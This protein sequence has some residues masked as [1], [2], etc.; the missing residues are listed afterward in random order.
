MEIMNQTQGTQKHFF[1][2][3]NAADRLWAEWIA[4]QLMQAGYEVIYQHWD[5]PPGSNFV[6]EMDKA[7]KQAEQTIAI[8]SSNYVNALY[9]QTEW[10]AAF[11]E[12]P[13]G[14]K[15]KL[16]P[17]RVQKCELGGILGQIVRI[18]LVGLSEEQARKT[19]LEG[20]GREP[21]A[22]SAPPVYPLAGIENITYE[23][24]RFPKT[25]PRIWNVPKRNL[26]FTGRQIYLE[27]LH[28]AFLAE[29][30]AELRREHSVS[31]L[32]GIGKTEIVI[33]Y[34]YRYRSHYEAVLWVRADSKQSIEHD[35]IAIAKDYLEFSQGEIGNAII[36]VKRW[37]ASHTD[38]LLIF[39]NVGDLAL[40]GGYVP[41]EHKGHVLLTTQIQQEDLRIGSMDEQE[42]AEFLLRRV[43]NRTAEEYTL[44]CASPEEQQAARKIS[45]TLDGHPLALDQAGVYIGKYHLPLLGYLQRYE[46]NRTK[47]LNDRGDRLS[48]HEES[49]VITLDLSFE[50]LEERS[51]DAALLLQFLTFLYPDAI[52]RKIIDGAL[53]MGPELQPLA[54]DLTEMDRALG[55]LADF[56]LISWSNDET[57]SIH[58][59]VRNILRD[60]I[61]AD[62][63]RIW[64]ERAVKVVNRAFPDI[65]ELDTWH[66]C[67]ICLSHAQECAQLVEQWKMVFPEAARLLDQIGTFLSSHL[68]ENSQYTKA[69]SFF[70][71]GLE[72]RRQLFGDE[73]PDVAKSIY[74]LASLSLAR[75]DTHQASKLFRQAE[76]IWCR[77]LAKIRNDPGPSTLLTAHI[78]N[79]LAQLYKAQEDFDKAQRYYND[80]LAIYQTFADCIHLIALIYKDLAQIYEEQGQEEQAEQSY[81]KALWIYDNEPEHPKLV[82]ILAPFAAM[83]FIQAKYSQ[84]ERLYKRQ[85]KICE[86]I[87]G[88]AHP[89]VVKTLYTL[90]ALYEAQNKYAQSEPL[91]QQALTAL[92]G[93]LGT[94][95]PEVANGLIKLASL[96]RI[97]GKYAQAEPLYKRAFAIQGQTPEYV[98]DDVRTHL[99]NYV[100]TLRMLNREAEASQIEMRALSF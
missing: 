87:L 96:Y 55:N 42:G 7:M 94:N 99:N 84:A 68:L 31:G 25:R 62:T 78:L 36:D 60:K 23:P 97:Q 11:R 63:Q 67:Q 56:S 64:A 43:K 80:A 46:R 29:W 3:F 48:R 12:D 38:W 32:G 86:H 54:N 10:A 1:I 77:S 81:S 45:Q 58:H 4:Y 70:C 76:E 50:K 88:L 19:L 75:G 28:R 59:L 18:D 34:A 65:I 53:D 57:L 93:R 66:S 22:P 40:I 73:H 41:T 90:A 47:L 39:D 89:K 51:A 69:E 13:K 17:V 24:P 71:K 52:S 37:L 95:H 27:D 14:E 15:R 35:F 85:L 20:I 74:H 9:T 16:L 5:F 79:D 44:D 91:Y 33:E 83:Y 2:S 30:S 8:I 92:E 72:M 49:V 26:Y 21:F 98:Y 6:I 61:V 82:A 100:D